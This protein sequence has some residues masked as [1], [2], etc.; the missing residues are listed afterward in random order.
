MDNH[1]HQI[2]PVSN[3]DIVWDF[4]GDQ[5]DYPCVFLIP[6]SLQERQIPED[7]R[8]ALERGEAKVVNYL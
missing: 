2:E 5:I 4:T 3:H 1:S 6:G 8:Q 7:I